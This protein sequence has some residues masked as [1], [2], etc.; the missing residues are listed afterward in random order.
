[1]MLFSLFILL[2]CDSTV[3]IASDYNLV[4]ILLKLILI[5]L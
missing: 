5:F 3:V 4:L 2:A 1:M